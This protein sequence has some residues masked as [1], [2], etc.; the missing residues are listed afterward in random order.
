MKKNNKFVVKLFYLLFISVMI[1]SCGIRNPELPIPDIDELT[2]TPTAEGTGTLS[3]MPPIWDTEQPTDV[4][5]TVSTVT[6]TPAPTLTPTP[7]YE[8]PVTHGAA[9]L[10]ELKVLTYSSEVKDGDTVSINGDIIVNEPISFFRM[11]SF[12]VNGKVECQYPIIVENYGM[13]ECKVTVA[14]GVDASELDIRYDAPECSLTWQGGSRYSDESSVAEVMNVKSYNGIDLFDKYGLGGIS[15]KH[16]AKVTVSDKESPDAAGLITFTVD[17]NVIYAN[18]SDAIDLNPIKNVVLTFEMSDGMVV[19]ESYDLT[20]DDNVYKVTDCSYDTRTYKIVTVIK[21]RNLPVF[22][23][24]INDGKEVSSKEEYLNATLTVDANGAYGDFPDLETMQMLIR[25]RGHFSWQFD[26]KSYKIRFEKKTSVL[27]MNASK[28]W[29]L[30]ANYVDRSL[31]QNYVAMEMGKVMTNI[32]YHSNQ[33]PVDVY[34]NGTYRGVYTFG[35]QLEAKEERMGLEKESADVDTDYLL[36]L[37][38]TDD[39][40]E[41]G[42]D[43]FHGSLCFYV[44]VK[45]PKP[46]VMTEE[47]FDYISDYVKKAD[48][49]VKNLS[50]YEEYIDVDSL[51]DWVIIHELTYN[52]DCSFRRSCFMIKEKG[53]KLK[54]GPI[55]DFDLAFGSHTRYQEGDFATIGEKNGYVGITWMNYLMKDEKFVARFK[56]RWNEIKERLL[57][58]TLTSIDYMSSL[59]SPSAEMNFKVWDILGKDVLSQPSSHKKYDTYEKMINRLKSFVNDRYD[60]LDGELNMEDNK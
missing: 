4:L 44:A 34:V 55:W 23:I 16:I 46:D 25:G 39:G 51:I 8:G 48:N 30:I 52:L 1:V 49:A 29:V 32:P 43:Y 54:T 5:P 35:E 50:G 41:K 19:T 26:K 6:S 57:E 47:Q 42:K 45:H 21:K 24:E 27:G 53:G 28:N 56:K 11:I 14:D 33:Y 20:A 38:G 31:I 58:T 2:K 22:Y 17:G 12:E 15:W 10:E 36:E 37:G 13:G 60:W 40:D 59:V 3:P 9:T 7:T 18:V